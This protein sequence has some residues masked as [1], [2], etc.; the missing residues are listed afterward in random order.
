[1]RPEF[2]RKHRGVGIL[3]DFDCPTGSVFGKKGAGIGDGVATFRIGNA[4]PFLL[5]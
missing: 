2:M 1:M 5:S 3:S 4:P